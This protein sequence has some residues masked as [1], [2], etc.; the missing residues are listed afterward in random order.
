MASWF[1]CLWAIATEHWEKGMA[2]QSHP[3]GNLAV[4]YPVFGDPK[5]PPGRTTHRNAKPRFIVHT[6]Q[7]GRNL[8][9]ATGAVTAREPTLLEGII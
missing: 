8:V 9:K 3:Y 5:R 2:E 1:H 6:I 7:A 4:L